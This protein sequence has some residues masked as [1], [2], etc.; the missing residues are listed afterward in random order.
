MISSRQLEYFQAVARELHFTR[1]AERL[2]IAQPALSQQIRKLERQLGL[3]LFERDNH[4][5]ELTPAGA[6]LLGHADRILADLGAVEDEML[7][8]AD[9]T[10]GLIRIGAA[11]GLIAQLARLLA[12]FC[13]AYPAVTIEL[14][15]QTTDAMVADLYTGKLDVATLA[16][17]PDD[18]QGRLDYQ[19]LGAEALVLITGDATELA[20]RDRVAL[21]ELD[22]VDLVLYPPGSAVRELILAAL[23]TA[24]VT[25]RPRF[26]TRDYR[27]A[28]ALAS[29][30]LAAAIVPR[31]VA[32]E[33]GLPVHVVALDPEP[34]WT[35]SLAWSA[36]RRPAPALA[37]FL[38]F[39]ADNPLLASIDTSDV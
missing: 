39:T 6:A 21:A 33:P 13:A 14:Q 36:A 1:A 15:E 11:R 25:P 24:Q 23:A 34:A 8:W 18:A 30:D 5:V 19:P 38:A 27:T 37:A 32:T 28:R 9:G 7:G 2:R 26:E 4:R 29:V 31:S 16:R 3:R 17:R 12:A 22:G 20:A 10:R 35:P